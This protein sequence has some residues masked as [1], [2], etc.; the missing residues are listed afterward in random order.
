MITNRNSRKRTGYSIISSLV[1]FIL[2]FACLPCPISYAEDSS[3]SY[4]FDLTANGSNEVNVNPGD[5]ITVMLHLKRTDK[6]ESSL[7]Y[8]MQDEVNYDEKCFKLVDNGNIAAEN[9]RTVDLGRKDNTRAYYINFVSV[10][11]G[12][13]WTPDTMLGMFQLEVIGEYGK[14]AIENK[15]YLVST[16]NGLDSYNATANDLSVIIK[17]DMTVRFVTDGGTE[18]NDLI[19][20]YNDLVLRPADPV[21]KG[22]TF[23]GW[24]KDAECTKLWDF[25]KDVVEEDMTLYAGWTE[26]PVPVVIWIA[27]IVLLIAIILLIIFKHKTNK[28]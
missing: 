20:K 8:A 11:G 17:G 25:E 2:I 5:I 26:N 19:V 18:I 27:P 7:M 12:E 3:R 1:A 15:N 13:Q 14:T 6:E 23:F 22:Y 21:K 16:Q 4:L 9:I 28:E 10:A 24:Y